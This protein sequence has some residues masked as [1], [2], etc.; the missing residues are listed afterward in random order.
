MLKYNVRGE[1]EIIE[2]HRKL[3]KV[4]SKGIRM[5]AYT[6]GKELVADLKQDMKNPKSGR[7]YTVYKGIGGKTLKRPRLHRASAPSETP[8][9][10]TG[11]FRKSVGFDVRGNKRLE[12]GSGRDGLAN[13]AEFLEYGTSKM[14][15]RKPIERTVKKYGNKV[16][17]NI[18]KEI[19]KQIESLG[20][21]VKGG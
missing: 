19:N 11:E 15:A 13:Y 5:G 21:N 1:K 12:F 6:S 4:I 7:V 2:V 17:I 9:I 3:P 10:I 14:K 16:N 18:T 8:A 20:V